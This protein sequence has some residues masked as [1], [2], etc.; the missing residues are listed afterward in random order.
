M[1][2]PGHKT[3]VLATSRADRLRGADLPARPVDVPT[4]RSAPALERAGDLAPGLRRPRGPS[5]SPSASPHP[6]PHPHPHPRAGRRRAALIVVLAAILAVGGGGT[7]LAYV[8]RARGAESAQVAQAAQQ[9]TA[10]TRVFAAEQ[11]VLRA[12]NSAAFWAA[13]VADRATAVLAAN[14]TLDGARAA[15]AAAPQAGD[16]ARTAL[17]A[18]IDAASAVVGAVPT[19]SVLTIEAAVGT[20]AG[21]Q[22]AVTA[23]QA[24]WQVTEDARLVASRA[25]TDAAAQAAAQAAARA[26]AP[27]ARSARAPT[28]RAP[29]PARAPGPA[30]PAPAAPSTTVPE[31]SAAALGA[32]INSWRATQGLPALS[33]SRS[34]ALVAQSGA[35][36]QAGDIW[37]GNAKIVGYVQPGSAAGL[38]QAW[39]NSPPHR[40]WMARTDKTAM[41]VGAVIVNNRLYGAVNFT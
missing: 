29:A 8:Q 35:M 39:A 25:A 16:A 18:A 14:V 20:L 32:A 3:R 38:V 27:A 2:N 30:A 6:H 13:T 33:I 34:A 21:P 23:A 41:Q 17:Q 40:A 28:P 31:F 11:R 12:Q 7:T 19:T 1:E 22:Q 37:D 15:L 24:G 36:A 4:Q 5:P 26:Q 9:Q 10:R